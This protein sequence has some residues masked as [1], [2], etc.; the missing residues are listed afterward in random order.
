MRLGVTPNLITILGALANAGVG[1]LAA[2]GNLTLAGIVFVASGLLDGLDG[3]LARRL[4]IAGRFGAF[5][6]SALD[7][8]SEAFVLFGLLIYAGDRGMV[9]EER[10]VYITLVGSLLISYTRARAEGLRVECRVGLLTR[11]ERYLLMA[12][13]LITGQVT[14]G[15][16]ILAVLTHFTAFQRI[17]HVRRIMRDTHTSGPR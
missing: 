15:L 17:L 3:A 10:L 1:V 5:L 11:M 4:G 7:R 8:Y 14:I 13:M 9:L 12:A 2:T 16:V 6:D